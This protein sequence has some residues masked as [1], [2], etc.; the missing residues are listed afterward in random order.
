MPLADD[1]E[2][3]IAAGKVYLGTP[4]EFGSERNDTTTFD[5]SD[6]VQTMFWDAL[7]FSLPS[8]SAAQGT[9]LNR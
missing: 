9:M 2:A 5:C 4:Y 1:I 6:F 3:V 8:D 7:H